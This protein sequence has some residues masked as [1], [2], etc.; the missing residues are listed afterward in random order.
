MLA[1]GDKKV[2]GL[3]FNSKVWNF[4]YNR[5]LKCDLL[6]SYTSLSFK[7]SISGGLMSWLSIWIYFSCSA[8]PTIRWSM[9]SLITDSLLH[10]YPGFTLHLKISRLILMDSICSKLLLSRYPAFG[11]MH[12]IVFPFKFLN[13]SKSKIPSQPISGWVLLWIT[14]WSSLWSLSTLYSVTY[15][16]KISGFL[17]SSSYFLS[18]V[19]KTT[20]T[21]SWKL[22]KPLSPSSSRSRGKTV[23]PN[24]S[25]LKVKKNENC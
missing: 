6:S 10:V 4:R 15:W 21:P 8:Y 25:F 20:P 23:S 19:C 14:F 16:L 5:Y 1:S 12:C 11:S 13:L 18:A 22:A 9:K 24:T 7:L 17:M 3:S 2:K